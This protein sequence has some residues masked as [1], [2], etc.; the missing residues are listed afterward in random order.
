MEHNNIQLFF[1]AILLSI[2]VFS[3]SSYAASDLD[4]DGILDDQDNCIE[5]ANPEQR[6]SNSDGYGNICDADLDN[7]G[8]VSFADLN[9]F[10]SAFGTTNADADFDGNGSVSFG[11]LNSFRA[12]FGKPPGPAADTSENISKAEASRFLTQSTFGPTSEDIQHLVDLKSYENWLNEQFNL[13]PNYHRPQIKTPVFNPADDEHT[14]QLGRMDTW[15]DISVFGEDQLRQRVAFALS[16]ILIISDFPNSIHEHRDTVAEYYDILVRHSFGNFRDLLQDVTLSPAMG[17][18]LSMLGNDKPDP[19]INRRA[20]ENYA[21]EIMQLFSIGLVELNTNGTQKLDSG[22]KPIPTFTQSDVE[23]L[24]RIFTGWSWNLDYYSGSSW[25]WWD[26][27]QVLLQ[28]MIA[29]SN[30]HD[31]DNKLFLGNPFSAGQTAQ[32]DLNK[33]LDII[34]NHHNVG[35]FIS[36]QLIMRLVTSNPSPAYVARVATIFN[37]NGQGIKGDLKA[38]IKTILLD[39]EARTAPSNQFGK[40]REPILRLTHL[41]RAFNASGGI[42]TVDWIPDFVNY[43]AFHYYWPEDEFSQAPMRSPSVFNFFRPDYSPAGK[44]KTAGLIAPEFQIT[45]ES[46][47]Q[48]LYE[49]LINLTFDDG[50]EG[51]VTAALDLSAETALV[52]NPGQLISHLDLLLTS[53]DMSNEIRQILVNY[54]NTNRTII[55]DDE[56]L[57]RD[58]IILIMTSAEYSIQR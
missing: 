34:F 18:Y 23:N 6:D 14:R 53:G 37:N 20:D 39:Q 13:S 30:H 22:G 46:R 21:R 25:E 42:A 48:N 5:I 27:H 56:R 12:L 3:H 41:W 38:V 54:V 47:L 15:W 11:D 45:S 16:E 8:F 44:I 52:N 35:P 40:L 29:F 19:S 31:K 43:Q 51:Y 57:V 58:L 1:A 26:E 55:N 49:A 33:A 9:L 50:F 7:N 4:G 17:I 10:R 28:P 32:Q 36:K 24:A 2:G